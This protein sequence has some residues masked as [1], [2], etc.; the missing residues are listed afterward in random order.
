MFLDF[1]VYMNVHAQADDAEPNDTDSKDQASYKQKVDGILKKFYSLMV[2]NRAPQ[3]CSPKMGA[4]AVIVNLFKL[5]FK[6]SASL[7]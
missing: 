1:M 4:V 7:F 5:Y 2:Q 6:V 3:D